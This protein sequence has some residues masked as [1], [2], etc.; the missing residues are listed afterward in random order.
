MMKAKGIGLIALL[1]VTLLTAGCT[2]CTTTV[3]QD[4]GTYKTT[5]HMIWR[6]SPEEY[7]SFESDK[8]YMIETTWYGVTYEW[9]RGK[10]ELTS[11]SDM[12]FHGDSV[13]CHVTKRA[14]T[15]NGKSY[16]EMKEGTRVR[17]TGEG[18][19]YV[20]GVKRPPIVE[21]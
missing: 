3:R 19:V 9:P 6:P 11:L 16:G 2:T 1:L 5:R 20:D 8:D 17:L 10:S 15:V 14:L 4:D 21:G 13:E 7:R 12:E 18:D